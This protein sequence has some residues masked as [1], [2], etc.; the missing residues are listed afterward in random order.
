MNPVNIFPSQNI[1]GEGPLWSV[2]E[3]AIY[4][5]DIDGK[6]IQ[7]FYPETKKYESFMYQLKSALWLSAKKAA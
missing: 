7:R 1:L 5:V 6:K 2:K 3:Q 4:W